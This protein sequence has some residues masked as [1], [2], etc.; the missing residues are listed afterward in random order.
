MNSQFKI[1]TNKNRGKLHV[2]RVFYTCTLCDVKYLVINPVAEKNNS[3]IFLLGHTYLKK[4]LSIKILYIHILVVIV[5]V[6]CIFRW[7]QILYKTTSQID[8]YCCFQLVLRSVPFIEPERVNIVIRNWTS[9]SLCQTSENRMQHCTKH[10][11]GEK[12][13]REMQ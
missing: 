10:I 13:K 7:L 5:W 2:F 11:K 12:K 3:M 6:F 1:S 4:Y 9:V 8:Q